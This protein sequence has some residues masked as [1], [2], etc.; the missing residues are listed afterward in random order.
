MTFW[1]WESVF[2]EGPRQ[3]CASCAHLSYNASVSSS[4][5]NNPI[6]KKDEIANIV[7]SKIRADGISSPLDIIK[8]TGDPMMPVA[9]GIAESYDGVLLLA[10]GLRCSRLQ[11]L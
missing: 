7:L 5:V 2:L 1:Y 6:G 8:Y 11:H 10:G 4:F 3:H 9:V